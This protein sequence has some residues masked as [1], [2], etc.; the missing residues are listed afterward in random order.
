EFDL[1]PTFGLEQQMALLDRSGGDSQID[2][3]LGSI[4]AF[5]VSVGT[6]ETAPAAADFIDP[7][8]MQMVMDDP[9][10]AAFATLKD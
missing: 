4:G 3:W 8:F 9:V 1:R 7:K 5:M 6:V 2:S 10:L